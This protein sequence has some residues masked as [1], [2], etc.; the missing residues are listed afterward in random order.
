[1]SRTKDLL[2]IVAVCSLAL[3]SLLVGC[4]RTDRSAAAGPVP[5]AASA[6]GSA[7]LPEVVVTAS[8]NGS[9]PLLLSRRNTDSVAQ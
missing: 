6:V 8:R 4:T 5:V 7:E 3:G 1:M 2:G 9:K